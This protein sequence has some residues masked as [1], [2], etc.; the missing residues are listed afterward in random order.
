MKISNGVSLPLAPIF[1]GHLYVQLDILQSDERH[2]SSC[3]I[4][5]SSAH[6]TILH[7]LLWEHCARH[8]AK[9]KPVHHAEEKY[10]SCPKVITNFYGCFVIEFPL[11]YHWVGLKPFGLPDMV[12]FDKEVGFLWRAYRNLGSGSLVLI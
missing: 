12:F 5:T 7:H 3:H 9:C 1:L 4:I 10:R 6:S 11:A 8:L 2:A